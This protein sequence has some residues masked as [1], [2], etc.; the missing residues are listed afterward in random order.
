VISDFTFHHRVVT[1]GSA[2][3]HTHTALYHQRTPQ[4]NRHRPSHL[5]PPTCSGGPSPYLQLHNSSELNRFH[6]C[7]RPH[8]L[9]QLRTDGD[10]LTRWLTSS[11]GGDDAAS[12][13]SCGRTRSLHASARLWCRA[14]IP[15]TLRPTNFHQIRL[16]LVRSRH[17]LVHPCITRLCSIYIT[18][19]RSRHSNLLSY[20]G[21]NVFQFWR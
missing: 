12:S 18:K 14:A 15:A 17:L 11:G 2:R 20:T 21:E 19:T 4:K 13:S 7:F 9:F 16:A 8:A 10:S 5:P 1:T 6:L 3:N